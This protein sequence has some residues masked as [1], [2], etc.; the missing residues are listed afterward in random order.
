MK[1]FLRSLFYAV[2]TGGLFPHMRCIGAITIVGGS[3]YQKGIEVGQG[4]INIE[5][6]EVRYFPEVDE[7]LAG[8]T[9]ESVIRA[10]SSK[11]SRDITMS[12]EVNAGTGAM[13]YT[14]A[15]ACT[16]AND[17]GTFGDGT[18]SILLDE[19]TETQSRSGWRSVSF[20]LS[21]NPLVIAS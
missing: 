11:F 18:G 9:G 4:G 7:K 1:N 14:L 12:G 20:K 6:F 5:S 16:V 17:V 3:G 13:A 15:T 21:S 2:V 8:I 19:V 10:F